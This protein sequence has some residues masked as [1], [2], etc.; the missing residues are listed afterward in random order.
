MRNR[1]LID[2]IYVDEN[3][4]MG[5][6]I[7]N[8]NAD[9]RRMM[10]LARVGKKDIFYDL[11]SGYGQNLIIALTEFNVRKAV[12]FEN[13]KR[14]RERSIERLENW[15]NVRTDIKREMW[16]VLPHNFQRLLSGKIKKEVASLGEATVIFFGLETNSDD[17]RRIAKGWQDISGPTRRLV[18]YRNCLFPEI[19]PTRAESPF[20]VSEF[21]FKPTTDKI[22]W[23]LKVTGKSKSSL[24]KGGQ[25]G[26]TEL[27]DD[28]RHDYD[29]ERSDDD[30][31]HYRARLGR[32]V[33]R[34]SS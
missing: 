11:G 22:A 21:P 10:T 12:G 9:I 2:D 15:S 24:I 27:W 13:D 5:P 32:A 31:S 16:E 7:L 33:R 34:N 20:L 26:E 17:A 3:S 4:V 14:R 30:L 19:M 23:L 18:Y 28:L 29:I 6:P 1:S 25:L 8:S